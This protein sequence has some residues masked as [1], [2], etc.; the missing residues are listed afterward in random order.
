MIYLNGLLSGI[1]LSI[2]AAAFVFRYPRRLKWLASVIS[3]F[4]EALE[5]SERADAPVETP[6]KAR[7][8]GK[9]V[10]VPEI[11]QVVKDVA[12]ALVG[13]GMKRK[14]AESAATYGYM[15]AWPAE[16]EPVFREALKYR[17][18]G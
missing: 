13:Q 14:E 17:R 2:A 12:D 4:A 7:R 15:Q 16:F 5:P 10:A 11:P 3:R 9:P 1:L 8:G 18:A 6:N